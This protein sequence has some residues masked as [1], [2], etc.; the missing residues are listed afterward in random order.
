MKNIYSLLPRLIAFLAVALALLMS[1]TNLFAQNNSPLCFTARNGSVTLKFDIKN[2]T[3]TIQYSTDGTS[4]STYTSNQQVALSADQSVYFRAES[5]QDSAVAF[6]DSVVHSYFDFSSSNGGTVEGSGNIMSLYGPNC[7]NLPLQ[8][9]AFAAM[10]EDCTPLT[11]APSLPATTLAESCY[12]QMFYGCTSLAE[13][14]ALPATTLADYCYCVMFEGCHSLTEAPALP[15]TTLADFCYAYMFEE[16]TSLATAPALPA[17]TLADYCY[18]SMFYECTSL[19][20][21]PTLPATT[22]ADY[23]YTFMFSECSSLVSAPTLPVTTL[24]DHCYD[25]MFVGFLW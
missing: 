3:H 24:T 5:N 1:A 10:F 20:A 6:A 18:H 2:A 15:A 25:A 13:A 11:T 21:A 22:L 17:T 4:W 14:P 19:T 8:P 23:C 16:C 12:R 9:Y 7:P